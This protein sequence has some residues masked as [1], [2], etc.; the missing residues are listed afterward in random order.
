M[1]T[2]LA[3]LSVAA[4]INSHTVHLLATSDEERAVIELDRTH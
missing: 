4:K 3:T 1:P 2:T